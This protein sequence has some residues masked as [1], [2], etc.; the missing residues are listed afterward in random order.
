[1]NSS[2]VGRYHADA[3][4]AVVGRA[5]AEGEDGVAAVFLKFSHA[6]GHVFVGGIGLRA[7]KNH[8][9]NAGLCQNILDLLRHSVLSEKTVGDDHGL[10]PA[11]AFHQFS[12]L[13]G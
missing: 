6:R 9:V 10:A 4:C 5:A 7:G 11:Q 12:G 1:M 2:S 3:L 8:R 13:S